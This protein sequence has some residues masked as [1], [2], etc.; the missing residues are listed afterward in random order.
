MKNAFY[1]YLKTEG[2]FWPIQSALHIH[3]FGYLWIQATVDENF[4]LRLVEARDVKSSKIEG[5]VYI[6]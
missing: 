6:Y 1:F 2:T 5:Q 3:S 4:H